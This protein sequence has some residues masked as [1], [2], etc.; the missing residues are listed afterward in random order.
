[1]SAN[2]TQHDVDW[3][4]TLVASTDKLSSADL[5]ALNNVIIERQG[6]LP[7]SV[8]ELPQ[9]VRDRLDP[10]SPLT[11]IEWP[12]VAPRGTARARPPATDDFY[13]TP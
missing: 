9:Q 3:L 13:S 8:D 2:P 7:T 10:R 4:R 12:T 11:P 1:M 5:A 6:V